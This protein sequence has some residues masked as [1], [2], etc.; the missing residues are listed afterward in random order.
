LLFLLRVLVLLIQ[1]LCSVFALQRGRRERQRGSSTI[2][3]GQAGRQSTKARK[4]GNG[5]DAPK[6]TGA[7]SSWSGCVV[8]RQ[9]SRQEMVASDYN[10]L[11]GDIAG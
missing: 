11:L 6:A 7:K 2:W 10:R 5:N 1:L 8:A 4:R 9:S 3:F